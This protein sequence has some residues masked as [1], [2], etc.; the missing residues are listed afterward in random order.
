[1]R[2]LWKTNGNL[3][4]ITPFGKHSSFLRPKSAKS[5]VYQ[6]SVRK[7]MAWNWKCAQR[8][9]FF[10]YC[11]LVNH[12]SV[13]SWKAQPL[14]WEAVFHLIVC[15]STD[16]RCSC[17]V[18]GSISVKS[19]RGQGGHVPGGPWV[20][21]GTGH[22]FDMQGPAEVQTAATSTRLDHWMRP[23]GQIQVIK[24]KIKQ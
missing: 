12:R 24:T 4:Y 6:N 17:D 5:L 19:T 1:M 10:P 11:F 16:G 7:K 23:G 21:S 9:V 22:L 20:R 8:P 14:Q 3:C 15:W 18:G 2:V 13:F